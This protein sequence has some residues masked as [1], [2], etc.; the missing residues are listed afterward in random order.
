MTTIGALLVRNEAAPDRYL[1][2]CAANA[3]SLCDHVV[4]LDDGSTDDTREKLR[5]LGVEVIERSASGG[6]WGADETTPRAQ[7]WDLASQRGDWIYVFDADH[8]LLGATRQDVE[9]LCAA[10]SVDA[11]AFSLYDCWDSLDLM[12]VDSWWQAHL[13]PRPWLLRLK[14]S[15]TFVPEWRPAGVHSGHTPRNWAGTIFAAPAPMAIRH[16]SYVS[17]AHRATKVKQYLNL[18]TQP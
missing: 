5:A 16:W 6:F 12:R 8:E 3:L 17:S 9:M 2:R 4:A 1:E 14:P 13:H 10:E 7:L 18:G 15:S 11:W